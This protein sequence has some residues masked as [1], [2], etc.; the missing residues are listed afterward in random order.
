[1]D[2][3]ILKFLAI[4]MPVLFAIIGFFLSYFFKRLM[5]ITDELNKTVSGLD[6]TI[7]V[8]NTVMDSQ[9]DKMKLNNARLNRHSE[10]L[11]CHETDI[12]L[13]KNA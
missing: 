12:S 13:L 5:N 11:D 4:S 1:M 7:R 10:R 2:S 9:E 8:M 6:A 3:T